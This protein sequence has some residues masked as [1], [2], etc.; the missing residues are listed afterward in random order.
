MIGAPCGHLALFRKFIKVSTQ[1]NYASSYNSLPHFILRSNQSG[2][3]VLNPGS[4][5]P[6][7]YSLYP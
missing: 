2:A 3:S 1:K 6:P 5:V 7:G 4:L